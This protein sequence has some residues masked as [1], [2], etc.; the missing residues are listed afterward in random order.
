MNYE[1]Y[2]VKKGKLDLLSSLKALDQKLLNEKIKEFDVANINELKDSILDDFE[3]CLNEAKDDYFTKMYFDLL[4]KNENAEVIS[5]LNEDIESLIVFVY[6]N[7]NSYSYYIPTEIKQIINKILGKMTPEEKF[8]LENAINTPIIKDLKGLLEHLSVKDLK[9]IGNLLFV[10]KLEKKNKKE[11]VK[12]VYS[13][14]IDKDKLTNLIV[15]FID[16]EFNLLKDLIKNKGT[17]Q[18]N[19]ID[20]A[21]Y[22]FLYVTGLVFIFRRENKFYISMTDDVYNVIKR[23][24]LKPIQKIVDENTKVY[25]LVKSMVELYGVVSADNLDNC[26]SLYYGNGSKLELPSNALFFCDRVDNIEIIHRGHNTYFIHQ[27]L[28]QEFLK[29][30][31]DD[32]ILRQKEIKRKPIKLE[33]LLKYANYD[34]YEENIAKNKF[35]EYLRKQ[36]VPSDNIEFIIKI[37]SDMNR[38]GDAF[39]EATLEM[40]QDFDVEVT[41]K[42]IQKILDHLSE[43][44]NNSR[45]WAN[46]GW[47]PIELFKERL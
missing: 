3:F 30:V 33:D 5:A 22:H 2:L 35:K 27:I 13:A 18:D 14:L 37:I 1:K 8:N 11:L 6:K 47:T 32:I 43:I 15:R 9:N 21:V 34:Y 42:N 16:K 41:E 19:N 31:L 26:Y 25:N 23:I 29:P 39:V 28:K 44:F 17:I 10:D 20:V 7:N 45:I 24:D 46:F 4:V 12:L 36:D 38:L 40:F